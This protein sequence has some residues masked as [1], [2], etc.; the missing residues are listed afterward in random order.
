MYIFKF[1]KN[2]ANEA[3]T[4]EGMQQTLKLDCFEGNLT[5]RQMDHGR[6]GL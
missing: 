4:W 2:M 3:E 1:K 6:R 5:L